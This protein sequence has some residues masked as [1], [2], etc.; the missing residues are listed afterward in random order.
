M[1]CFRVAITAVAVIFGIA[2]LSHATVIGPPTT[3]QI[4]NVVAS[5][6][7]KTSI[8]DGDMVPVVDLAG[9]NLLEKTSW[10]NF[11]AAIKTYTDTLYGAGSTG[12]AAC[13]KTDHTLGYCS[14][15]VGSSG[16]C[17]CN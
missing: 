7:D 8:S 6:I 9:G 3:S 17:T 11:K 12:K 2:Y 4:G 16:G 1:K 14:S 5:G 10:L 15:T 13:W